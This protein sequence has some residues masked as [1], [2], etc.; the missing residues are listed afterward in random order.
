MDGS[1]RG[2]Q[3]CTIVHRPR[4]ITLIFLGVSP[5]RVYN[6]NTVGENGVIQDIR[7]NVLQTISTQATVTISHNRKSHILDLL[8]IS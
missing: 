1:P 3:R 4:P 5:L 7:E 2:F 6:P 8:K